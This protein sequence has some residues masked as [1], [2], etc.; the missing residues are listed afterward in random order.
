MTEKM[1]I[2]DFLRENQLDAI[3]VQKDENCRYL[4]KFTGSDSYL[5]LTKEELYLLTDSRYTEQARKE[6]AD[7]TVVDYKGHLAEIVAKLAGEYHIKTMGVE[8]VFSYQMYLSFHEY[9]PNIEF[10]FSQIDRLRQIKSEE[11]IFC[12]KEAC[13]ISDAGFKATLPF[14]RAG[15][16]EARLR[17][18]LECAM[19]EEGSEGK[20][21]DTIVASGERSAYPHGVATGK[22][23]EDGDLVTFDFGAIYKDGFESYFIHS[24]GHS[25]GLEIHESPFLS[26]RD[27]TVLKENM[28]ETVEPGVYIPGIGGVR[29]EDTVVIK[30]D[31]IEVLTKFPKKFLRM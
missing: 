5:L 27:H 20:S 25:V 29:I 24:L 1:K 2:I 7:Y 28:I 8:T 31:G 14:I 4:S 10:R 13:R 21:F 18:I 6:S 26:A 30:K 22:V 12:I 17:T 15:I 11:E 9:M 23:L 3:F 16:T 19:L